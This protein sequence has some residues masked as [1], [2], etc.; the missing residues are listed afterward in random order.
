MRHSKLTSLARFLRISELWWFLIR[1][2]RK[3]EAEMQE[4][5]KEIEK[6]YKKHQQ[7]LREGHHHFHIGEIE[8][9]QKGIVADR[10]WIRGFPRRAQKQEEIFA[11][12]LID[13]IVMAVEVFRLCTGNEN[14]INI[15]HEASVLG[16]HLRIKNLQLFQPHKISKPVHWGFKEAWRVYLHKELKQQLNPLIFNKN[17]HSPSRNLFNNMEII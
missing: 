3:E 9:N 14:D 4:D 5:Q 13:A 12:N 7:K 16:V 11:F 15:F 2:W 8:P 10:S 1:K 6:W 17:L